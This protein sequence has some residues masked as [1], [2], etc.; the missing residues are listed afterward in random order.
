M[1]FVLFLFLACASDV[2]SCCKSLP[3]WREYEVI[4]EDLN[5]RTN[6]Y[7]C[8]IDI[9]KSCLDILDKKTPNTEECMIKNEK[10]LQEI[11]KVFRNSKETD[12]H[13]E[14]RLQTI[15]TLVEKI[16]QTEQK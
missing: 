7:D 9:L 15:G 1:F 5:V 14:Y 4:V 3:D 13:M 8:S 12:P 2:F 6:V 10:L 16:K 11:L